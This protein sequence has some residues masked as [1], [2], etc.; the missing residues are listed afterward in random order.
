MRETAD[1]VV[2]GG[3]V[4]GT[5]VAY[6]LAKTKRKV[7]LV[8][9]GEMGAQTSGS[10]DK[11]IFLQSK[12]PGFSVKLAKA[13]RQ[14][15]E[16]LEDELDAS[17]EF[18]KDGGMIVI[19]QEEH[20]EFMKKFVGKQ[21]K[22]GIKV[23]L[24]DRKATLA[25]QPCLS[26]TIYGATYSGEDAEVN[27]L[28][29]SQALAGASERLGVNIHTHTE[30]TGIHV[31]NGKVSGVTTTK[32]YIATDLV[33]NAAGPFA[34]SIAEMVGTTLTIIPRRGVI[35]I[36]ER[37]PRTINGNILCSQYIATKHLTDRSND[38]TP[39]YGIGLSLGQTATGNLLIG[40]SREFKGFDREVGPDVV[41]AIAAHACRI[42]PSLK[43]VRVIRTMTGF[44]PFTPDG[45]PVI[46][47][48]DGI[49]GF[50]I[51]AGHE[52]DG[53]ALSPITGRLVAA[54]VDGE[55]EY[56]EFLDAL[57]LERLKAV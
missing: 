28:L 49:K 31:M 36:T 52:G 11:A 19:E 8:E 34:P 46:D 18:K 30:V 23:N 20:M 17:I 13:S 47:E 43:S 57:K 39:P 2:I 26:K 45:L 41:A 37:I 56:R 3:G 51:A 16:T 54:L 7:I 53:I 24:L 9:K 44:R 6:H 32:G 25:W 33:I 22:A 14:M 42:A 21:S 5:S 29:L 48:V 15:Y 50:I 1:A 10:C 35:L 55:E 40:G 38:N 27:P 4:I 12:N